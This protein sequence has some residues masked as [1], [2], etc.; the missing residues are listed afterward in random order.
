MKIVCDNC[1]TKYQIADEKVSGKAFKIRCK[2]CGHVIVV[3]KGAGDAPS[4]APAPEAS[5]N[6][7]PAPPAAEAAPP[8]DA[9][10]HLVIER[11]QVG[12]M[13]P[14]EV[15]AKVRAGQ[16]DGETYGWREGF[17]DWLKLSAIEDFKGLFAAGD[18]QATRRTD[19]A[20]RSAAAS[21]VAA[22]GAD[23]FGGIGK[24]EPIRTASPGAATI[25]SDGMQAPDLA[26]L[27]LASPTSA[28][29][30]APAPMAAPIVAQM[31]A[32]APAAAP[33]A[34]SGMDAPVKSMTGARSENS[35][36]FSLNNL[37]ALAGAS[38]GAGGGGGGSPS[39]NKAAP[40][41][42][43]GFPSVQSEA[44]GLIDIR[45]MA[46]ATLGSSGGSG[47]GMLSRGPDLLGGNDAAPV[48]TP[49]A[50]AVLMPA[51]ETSSVP[52]WVWPLVGVGGLMFV[53]MIVML[54][55]VLTK[56]PTPGPVA[57]NGPGKDP[58]TNV[59]T[60]SAGKEQPSN[61]A[62][63]TPPST[64]PGTKPP[65][66]E[67]PT[68]PTKA[69]SSSSDSG[70]S[71]S[72]HSKESKKEPKESHSSKESKPDKGPDISAP[73]KNDT[74]PPPPPK[75]DKP[76]KPKD[77]LD[78]LLDSASSGSGGKPAKAEKKDLP[79]QLSMSQIQGALK[80]V[81]ASSCK[82]EG[83]SGVIK[84]KLTI[85]GNGKADASSADGA[86]GG[87]CVAK[88][89]KKTAFPEFSGDPMTL[90]YPFIIR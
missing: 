62:S 51:A 25:V 7:E 16:V 74:P 18:D 67:T 39:S 5:V 14:D 59:A 47:G 21:G 3:N 57:N 32:P 87:D 53:G 58:A 90:T 49:L 79:E 70:S 35:V 30:P 83:A 60:P 46:A 48:F 76:A 28:P 20:D 8:S 45:A 84:I 4:Q 72:S 54:V 82:G 81:D 50:P 78:S 26:A 31:S 71:H 23:L 2:K 75:K 10:W 73:P 34:A 88:A 15:R 77:D 66:A 12:P 24:D 68:P 11:E 33:V 40:S 1:A 29:A 52:K 13:T 41:D 69:G 43:Q 61:T 36:L 63:P 85:K 9:V 86:S 17:D 64:S 65:P 38:G 37:S 22:P 89:V 55:L 44:S 80:K 27:G 19:S 6:Q 42:K 56:E